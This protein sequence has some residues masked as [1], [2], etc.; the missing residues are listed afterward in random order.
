MRETLELRIVK[1]YID[2]VGYDK[3]QEIRKQICK[4]AIEK[5]GN[6]YG[7]LTDEQIERVLK[8]GAK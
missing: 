7:F 5:S 3:Y 2:M 8:F 1:E 4:R 6:M